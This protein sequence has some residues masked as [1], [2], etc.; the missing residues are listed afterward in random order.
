M[1]KIFFLVLLLCAG[2]IHAQYY[3][4][5]GDKSFIGGAAGMTWIDGNPNYSLRFFPEFQFANFGFGLDLNLDWNSNGNIRTENFNEA[6]DYISIIRFIR[7]GHKGDEIYARI[8]ALDYATIGHGTIVGLYNNNTSFDSKKVGFEFDMDLN[9]FGF[10]T[11]YGNFARAGLFAARGYTRPL[12]F[13]DL[14]DAPILG[15]L[16]AGISIATDMNE[17]AGILSATYYPEIDLLRPTNDKGSLTF[18]GFDLGLPL[19]RNDVINLDL[20]TDFNKIINFGSGAAIG[21]M[22]D[23]NG[24]GIVD[25][26][27]KIERQFNGDKYIPTYFNALYEVER[28]NLNKSTGVI[29]SKVQQLESATDQ[30]NGY[31]GELYGSALGLF[32]LLGSFQKLDR[33]SNSGILHLRGQIAPENLMFVFNLGYDKINIGSFSDIFTTDEHSY[34]FAELG[35]K[36]NPFLLASVVYHWNFT[37]IRDDLDNIVGYKPQKRIEPRVSLIYPISF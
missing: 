28:F 29:N 22:A 36:I 15:M 26:K 2:K 37:P 18:I 9:T 32:K 13:T 35:Y 24:L 1:K 12:Q 10:E 17:N 27:A 25:I 14:K 4:M 5:N 19:L 33:V 31:Y 34:L 6:S 11:L 8:G 16:E 23:F 21:L 30:S 7:Y 3:L 20:Y